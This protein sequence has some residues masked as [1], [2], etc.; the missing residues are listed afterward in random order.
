MT[1]N[2]TCAQRRRPHTG[3]VTG[4]AVGSS[5]V[6]ISA[7]PRIAPLSASGDS[8]I[9]FVP[10][11]IRAIRCA[12]SG[13]RALR[14]CAEDLHQGMQ[15]AACGGLERFSMNRSSC[16]SLTSLLHYGALFALKLSRTRNELLIDR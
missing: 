4:D 11:K 8:G 13:I 9:F 12:V 1:R 10:E 15:G 7:M 3:T 16:C 5:C 2:G 14:M 6:S